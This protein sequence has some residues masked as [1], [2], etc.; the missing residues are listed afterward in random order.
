MDEVEKIR[1]EVGEFVEKL[2]SLIPP[3]DRV[4]MLLRECAL[5]KSFIEMSKAHSEFFQ[6]EVFS[7][8]QKL[9]GIEIESSGAIDLDYNR[10]GYYLSELIA[11]LYIVLDD[12]DFRRE[13]SIFIGKDLPNPLEE[14]VKACVDAIKQQDA[15]IME[16]L[17]VLI[18]RSY[19]FEELKSELNKKGIIV[20]DNDLISYLRTLKRLGIVE[21]YYGYR[22]VDRVEKHL[23]S[24]QR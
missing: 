13:L 18:G 17:K 24:N 23:M 10:A 15:K 22:I 14:Y 20:E 19:K 9:L 5:S 12:D 21:E 3:Y 7:I 2:L 6:P 16:I 11:D 8:I 4:S 1:K